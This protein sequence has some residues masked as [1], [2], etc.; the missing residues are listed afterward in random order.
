MVAEGVRR[1]RA[2]QEFRSGGPEGCP[3]RPVRWCVAVTGATR[4]QA[5]HI[6][7]CPFPDIRAKR[8]PAWVGSARPSRRILGACRTPEARTNVKT[9]EYTPRRDVSVADAVPIRRR[10]AAPLTPAFVTQRARGGAAATLALDEKERRR[11]SVIGSGRS[12]IAQGER[13][14]A[15]VMELGMHTCFRTALA[16]HH[17]PAIPAYQ[18][19]GLRALL[20]A[21]S[22]SP[23]R[24]AHVPDLDAGAASHQGGGCKH[25]G[26]VALPGGLAAAFGQPGRRASPRARDRSPRPA[27]VGRWDG[28]ARGPSPNQSPGAEAPHAESNRRERSAAGWELRG[29]LTTTVQCGWWRRRRAKGRRQA[30]PPKEQVRQRLPTVRRFRLPLPR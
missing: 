17:K 18:G 20:R 12:R 15:A 25:Q 8:Q 16:S 10:S 4:V 9:A 3:V 14:S 21:Q 2:E 23:R 30:S 22:T 11:G 5:G 1:R 27:V 19:R 29:P 7:E 24:L 26:A 6:R 13:Q 28:R